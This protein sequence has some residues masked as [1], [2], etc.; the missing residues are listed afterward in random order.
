[1]LNMSRAKSLRKQR[2]D[3]APD[4]LGARVPEDALD[5]RVDANDDASPVRDDDRVGGQ[6][7]QRVAHR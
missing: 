5:L 3:G 4:D 7:E 2:L 6:L 1:M